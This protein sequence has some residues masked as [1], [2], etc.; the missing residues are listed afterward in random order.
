MALK[1]F[2]NNSDNTNDYYSNEYLHHDDINQ[3][4][5]LFNQIIVTDGDGKFSGIKI[6]KG[7]L[8]LYAA[9]SNYP[10]WKLTIDANGILRTYGFIEV[11]ESN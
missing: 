3:I 4:I 8:T 1:W 6:P 2:K 5:Q 10:E 9:D 7:G 11:K